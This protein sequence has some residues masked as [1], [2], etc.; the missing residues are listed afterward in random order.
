MLVLT[1]QEE[2]YITIGN[3]IKVSVHSYLKDKKQL[4]L[5]VDA[6]RELLIMRGN[7]ARYGRKNKGAGAEAQQV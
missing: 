4:V 2:Q 5:G 1:L 6:P 3:D 7:G